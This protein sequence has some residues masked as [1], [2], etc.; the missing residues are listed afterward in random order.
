[1]TTFVLTHGGGMG[2]WVWKFVRPLLREAGHD[3]FTPTFTGFGERIHLLSRDVDNATHVA[4]IVNVLEYEDISDCIMV[5]HSYAGTVMPGVNAAAGGRVR[6][7]V[8]LDGLISYAG[9]SI[10]EALGFMSRGQAQG[11]VEMVLSGQAPPGSGV[12]HQQRE[13]AKQQP[14]MMSREREKW[15]LDHLSDMPLLCTVNPL[16]VG[17]DTI[18]APVDYVAATHTIMKPMHDRA[19]ALGWHMHQIQGDHA[20]IVGEPEITARL[21]LSLV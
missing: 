3:V 2:G 14:H 13:M 17:A 5:G 15:L 19:R 16:A 4:D 12:H 6:R 10:A 9:E 7:Y 20:F 11:M 21:L 8:Y 18:R 1:M